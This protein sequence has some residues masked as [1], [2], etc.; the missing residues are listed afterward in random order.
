MSCDHII[1][2]LYDPILRDLEK[3]PASQLDKPAESNGTLKLKMS[4]SLRQMPRMIEITQGEKSGELVTT[5]TMLERDLVL[6]MYGF[7]L[8]CR[9][10]L[11]R[12]SNCSEKNADV[13]FYVGKI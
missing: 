2:R 8:R 3:I 4:D 10:T 5:W 13:L 1:A 9:V 12:E 7:D 6:K 11:H